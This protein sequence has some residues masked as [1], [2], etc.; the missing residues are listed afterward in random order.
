MCYNECT[1]QKISKNGQ[2]VVAQFCRE[3]HFVKKFIKTL[4]GQWY[5]RFQEIRHRF[6]EK[7]NLY[8]QLQNH[9][10]LF[11]KNWFNQV[12][13]VNY[14]VHIKKATIISLRI[15]MPVIIYNFSTM[16]SN[17]NFISN[18]QKWICFMFILWTPK[19][20]QY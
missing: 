4:Y 8:R 18:Q 17:H 1:F 15:A 13:H 2:T 16:F 19:S 7:R 6:R 5:F 10:F 9:N 12:N 14:S 3:I 20:R 11:I